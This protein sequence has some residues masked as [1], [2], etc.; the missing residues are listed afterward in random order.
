MKHN[1]AIVALFGMATAK[2]LRPSD[3]LTSQQIGDYN[4]YIVKQGKNPV[5]TEDYMKKVGIF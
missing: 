5:T 2:Q 4:N 1:F 3:G